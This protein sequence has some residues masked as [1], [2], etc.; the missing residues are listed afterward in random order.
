M[1]EKAVNELKPIYEFVNENI[2][3]GIGLFGA[4]TFGA[5]CHDFLKEKGYQI[6]CFVDTSTKKQNTLFCGLKVIAPSS[7]NDGVLLITNQTYANVMEQ[8]VRPGGGGGLTVR[9]FFTM[10]NIRKFEN[11]R[12]N[13]FFDDESKNVIDT[14]VYENLT[15][16]NMFWSDI[17][18]SDQYFCLEEFM[19][20]PY[21]VYVDIGASV[22]DSIERFIWKQNGIISQIYGFEPI[23]REYNALTRRTERLVHEWALDNNQII[24]VNAGIAEKTQVMNVQSSS[25]HAFSFASNSNTEETCGTAVNLYSLDD[26]FADKP[27]TFIKADVEGYEM[28]CLLGASDLIKRCKPKMAFC[29]YH[30]PEDIFNFIEYLS[31]L[32]PE[33]KFKLRHHSHI[34]H[35]TVLYAFL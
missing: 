10:K 8:S 2:C 6:S 34:W 20:C 13:I 26:Y 22:G 31:A 3:K 15:S 25:L 29:I 7:F 32:V 19:D 12:N 35:E 5:L 24:S 33:Y 18:T 28:K 1:V 27:V 30:K 16:K 11:I 4:G 23:L 14:M 9:A 21:E 17:Y